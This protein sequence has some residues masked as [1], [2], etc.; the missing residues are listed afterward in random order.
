[1][2]TA[3][4]TRIPLFPLPTTVLF[5]EIPLPLHIFE[6][7]YRAMTA[8]ALAGNN[9]I[10]MMLLKPGFDHEYQGN[11]PIYEVGCAG[12]ILRHE[13]LPDGRFN[14]ML[15]GVRRF[16][17]VG[18]VHGEPYRVAE[19]EYLAEEREASPETAEQ[20][21]ALMEHLMWLAKRSGGSRNDPPAP[22]EGISD[23]EFV[24]FVSH[25]MDITPL[26]KQA[27]LEVHGVEGRYR[28]LNDILS[29]W[30]LGRERG[31]GPSQ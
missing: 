30:R 28:K 7:R 4:P 6:P 11:P 1:M 18:E 22:P 8:A 26:E 3:L 31:V 5:P 21:A 14:I 12:M 20:R 10:G 9:V 23:Y 24:N 27:L 19:V 16:R 2:G 17:V 15:M 25:V 13:Q 29:F